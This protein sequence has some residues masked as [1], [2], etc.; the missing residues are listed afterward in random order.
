MTVQR[1]DHVGV[2]VNDLEAATEFFVALGLEAGGVGSV[3]GQL[4]DRIIGLEGARSEIAF[5]RTPDGKSQI[6]LT[7][8]KSPAAVDGG[9]GAPSNG[10]G[11][12]HLTFAVDDLDATVERLRAHGGELVGEIVQYEQSYRLCYL[13]GPEGIIIEL[14]EALRG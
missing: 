14:A 6:E 13:R 8:F 12:R 3:G 2:V 7:R 1:M 4:V 11:I 10:L 9:A 5:L